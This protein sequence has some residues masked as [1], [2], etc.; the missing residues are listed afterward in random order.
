MEVVAKDIDDPERIASFDTKLG[1]LMVEDDEIL[2]HIDITADEC[3]KLGLAL[4]DYWRSEIN[5]T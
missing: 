3:L 2:V 5:P 4:I 1:I